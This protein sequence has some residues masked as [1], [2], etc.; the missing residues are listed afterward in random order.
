MV[1]KFRLL[2]RIAY[3][4]AAIAVMVGVTYPIFKPKLAGASQLTSRSI[5]LS[6]S[7]QSGGA[8]TTGVGS[9]TNVTYQF[10]FTTTQA[11]Q[12]MVID[13]CNTTPLIGDTCTAPV[14][15]NA[16][17]GALVGVTGNIT[18]PGWTITTT[19]TQ[20]KLAKGTGAA[21]TSGVQ[22]FNI[23]GITNPS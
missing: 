20:I 10:S 12:S 2:Q 7:G 19:A 15:M 3:A 22:Q 23:T 9:G 21:A 8:I 11:A 14:G 4:M 17:A 5:T 16:T 1:I 13:F 18:S 6:D